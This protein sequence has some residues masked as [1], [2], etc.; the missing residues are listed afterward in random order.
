V[1]KQHA[2]NAACPQTVEHSEQ[3]EWTDEQIS[4][5]KKAAVLYSNN[6]ELISE[7]VGRS[8]DACRDRLSAVS[9]SASSM[10]VTSA[11]FR[12]YTLSSLMLSSNSTIKPRTMLSVSQAAKKLQTAAAS[13]HPSHEAAVRKANQNINKLLT[14]GELALRR[15]QRNRVMAGEL[16]G[17]GSTGGGGGGGSGSQNAS[18]PAT[19]SL[20]RSPS[21]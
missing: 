2:A 11:A 6:L 18:Q 14:P 15:L 21:K 7:V 1:D 4:F 16:G 17:S 8:P 5:L 19:P 12:H 20:A 3:G 13:V 9:A 10:S